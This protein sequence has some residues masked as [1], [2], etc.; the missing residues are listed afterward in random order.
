MVED[1]ALECCEE[2][3]EA[4]PKGIREES[5][6]RP[7]ILLGNDNRREEHTVGLAVDGFG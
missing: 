2:L 7:P 5:T 6:S 4:F 3:V 1:L